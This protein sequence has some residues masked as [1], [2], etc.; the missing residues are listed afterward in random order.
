MLRNVEEQVGM[1]RL[2]NVFC[3]IL[4]LIDENMIGLFVIMIILMEK[5]RMKIY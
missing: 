3:I 4:I 2:L 5:E 1:E